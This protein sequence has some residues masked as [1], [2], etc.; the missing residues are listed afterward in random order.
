M[1]LVLV[2]RSFLGALT[3]YG[4]TGYFDELSR[5]DSENRTYI[6]K[7]GPGCGK[8]SMMKRIGEKLEAEGNDIEYIHCSSD[9][10][11]LDG[12]ICER[13]GF[14]LAD[15]TSPHV[16][17]PALPAARQSVLS[18]YDCIDEAALTEVRAAL[19]EL[20]AKNKRCFERAGRFISASASLYSDLQRTAEGF[21]LNSKLER[22]VK[23]LSER[24]FPSKS[25][26]ELFEKNR[27][28]TA[29]TPDGI[30]SFARENLATCTYRYIL[31]DRF[32]A[33]AHKTLGL[34]REEAKK[35]GIPAI[36]CRSFLSPYDR[37]EA[38]FFPS[39]SLCFIVSGFLS[40]LSGE[41]CRVIHG[42]RFYDSDALRTRANR[43]A[44]CK[45]TVLSLLTQGCE[46]LYE[47][48]AVHGDIEAY[49]KDNFD[50]ERLHERE[51]DLL[52]KYGL[53]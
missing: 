29:A 44:F 24:V 10:Q 4:F 33:F 12:V 34:L 28:L 20:T 11:S 21:L 53:F 40:P 38:L 27:F 31:K 51:E 13:L 39:L 37:L 43:L 32:G 46:I 3:P 7:G 17:E 47:A 6:I 9:P 23:N 15:G 52:T 14:A 18:L 50:F 8:S 30:V 45:K 16:L 19:T 48:R 49:F 26:A 36:V 35:R 2:F 22:Y 1:V 5:L 42:S 41:G 25:E